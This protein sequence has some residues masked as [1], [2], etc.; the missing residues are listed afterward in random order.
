MYPKNIQSLSSPI[1]LEV[2]NIRKLPE[3]NFFKWF[4]ILNLMMQTQDFSQRN[5]NGRR[6]ISFLRYTYIF[7][8]I[9][10]MGRFLFGKKFE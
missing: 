10:N 4:F 5:K 9:H 7:L 8:E 3:L 2:V 6:R 1:R